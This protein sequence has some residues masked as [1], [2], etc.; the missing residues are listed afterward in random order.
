[1]IGRQLLLYA[2]HLRLMDG[3]P[4]RGHDATGSPVP[5][6]HCHIVCPGMRAC[7]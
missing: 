3:Y 7:R 5:S 6:L 4:L 1:M 2:P